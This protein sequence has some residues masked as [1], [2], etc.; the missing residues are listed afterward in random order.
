LIDNQIYYHGK[1]MTFINSNKLKPVCINRNT[2]VYLSDQGRGLGF[3][4]VRELKIPLK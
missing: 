4:T 2:I 1:Q 3:Y